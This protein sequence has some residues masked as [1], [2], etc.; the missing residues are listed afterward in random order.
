MVDLMVKS[1]FANYK[2]FQQIEVLPLF[3]FFCVIDRMFDY[4]LIPEFGGT[5]TDKP[6]I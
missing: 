5:T 4:Q 1:T 6:I 2:L 3:S